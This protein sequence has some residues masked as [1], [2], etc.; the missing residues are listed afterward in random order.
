MS[1]G[2]SGFVAAHED[3]GKWVM[4]SE[5]FRALASAQGPFVS[6]YLDDSHDSADAVDRL[7]ATW[8]DLRKHLEDGGTGSPPC[9]DTRSTAI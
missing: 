8:R 1:L 5:R 3:W 2:A 4:E 9:C 7:E 6:V